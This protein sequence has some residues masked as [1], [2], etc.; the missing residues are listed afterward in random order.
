M[1]GQE[2]EFL[3]NKPFPLKSVR[4]FFVSVLLLLAQ[5]TLV[6][7]RDVQTQS[8]LCWTNSPSEIM[9]SNLQWRSMHSTPEDAL[10]KEIQRSKSYKDWVNGAVD[11]PDQYA[12]F[13]IGDKKK[14]DLVIV[15]SGFRFSSGNIFLLLQKRKTDLVKLA[16]FQGAFIFVRNQE[17]N[18]PDLH[19]YRREGPDYS[20][21]VS[22][23]ING[24]FIELVNTP[25]PTLFHKSVNS[26]ENGISYF[27]LN[28]EFDALWDKLN[29]TNSFNK[30]DKDGR[31]VD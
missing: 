29:A 25:F 17:S 6:F 31:C 21:S 2:N 8:S 20:F 28:P 22:R 1:I 5:V 24:K 10:W 15:S 11:S 4:A 7:A 19:V 13:S 12:Y 3:K 27:K 26:D 30:V 9:A 23:F 16:E 14:I 18:L